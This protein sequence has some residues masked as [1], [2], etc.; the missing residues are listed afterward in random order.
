MIGLTLLYAYSAIGLINV[1]NRL[2]SLPD[3]I[4]VQAPEYRNKRLPLAHDHILQGVIEKNA[5]GEPGK[6]KEVPK[7]THPSRNMEVNKASSACQSSTALSAVL[8]KQKAFTCQFWHAARS[9]WLTDSLQFHPF[10][11]CIQAI[12]RGFMTCFA[13]L[14]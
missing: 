2:Q 9:C 3:G 14:S 6:P 11:S 5:P 10:Q 1:S 8:S 12:L 13:S 7:P 4:S